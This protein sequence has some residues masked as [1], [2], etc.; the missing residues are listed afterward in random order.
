MSLRFLIDG[1]TEQTGLELQRT[2]GLLGEVVAFTRSQVDLADPE[3]K[4]L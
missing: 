4:A 2:L 3:Q 1:A